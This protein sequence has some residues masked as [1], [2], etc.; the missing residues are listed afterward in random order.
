MINNHISD[1]IID[2]EM[3]QSNEQAWFNPINL[4]VFRSNLNNLPREKTLY[5][6][7]DGYFYDNDKDTYLNELKTLKKNIINSNI[8]TTS[9]KYIDKVFKDDAPKLTVSKSEGHPSAFANQMYAD[10]LFDEITTNSQWNF[11]ID[12]K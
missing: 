4:C 7:T 10:I 6:I 9:P 2:K 1:E 11:L 12:E 8:I 3:N 5:F